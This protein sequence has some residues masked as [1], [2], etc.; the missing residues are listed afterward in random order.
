MLATIGAKR[1]PA[2]S[3]LAQTAATVDVSFIRLFPTLGT[4]TLGAAFVSYLVPAPITFVSALTTFVIWFAAKWTSSFVNAALILFG[5]WQ[6][7]INLLKNRL[8]PQEKSAPCPWP[9]SSPTSRY[10]GATYP[11]WPFTKK[12]PPL[13]AAIRTSASTPAKKI[14]VIKNSE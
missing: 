14:C 8:I 2:S 10:F 5:L 3:F 1:F 13:L 6:L 12:V 9:Q 11:A 4:L 7:T